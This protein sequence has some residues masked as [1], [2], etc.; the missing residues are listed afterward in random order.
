MTHKNVKEFTAIRCGEVKK[1]VKVINEHLDR[2][3][4]LFGE[5]T[6]LV[7][8]NDIFHYQFMVKIGRPWSGVI[9][10]DQNGTIK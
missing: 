6:I 5:P 2:G 1:F 7:Y 9:H 3:W 8:S 4:C 10:E